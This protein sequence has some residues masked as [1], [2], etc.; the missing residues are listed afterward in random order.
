M[1]YTI[2]FSLFYY[3]SDIY[4]FKDWFVFIWKADLQ[5]E[6]ELEME[7][8]LSF[9]GSEAQA[10]GGQCTKWCQALPAG[11]PAASSGVFDD[12]K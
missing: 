12:M 10:L 2:F 5:K 7:R 9:A 4:I 1:F 11:R 3:C 6:G 8:F